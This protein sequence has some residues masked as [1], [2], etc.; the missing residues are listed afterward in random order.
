[1][2]PSCDESEGAKVQ[3]SRLGGQRDSEKKVDRLAKT[4]KDKNLLLQW[5]GHGVLWT[6]LVAMVQ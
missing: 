3:P 5:S 1:M 6:L 4:L 2:Q